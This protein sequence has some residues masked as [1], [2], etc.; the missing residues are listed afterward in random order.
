MLDIG[1]S[2]AEGLLQDW[3]FE[4]DE[5]SYIKMPRNGPVRKVGVRV[6]R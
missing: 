3:G 1:V 6:R 4:E 5:S 2:G